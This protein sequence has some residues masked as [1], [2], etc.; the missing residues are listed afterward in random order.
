MWR[1]RRNMEL[2]FLRLR[3][4][5]YTCV[6]AAV[7]PLLETTNSPAPEHDRTFACARAMALALI[8]RNSFRRLSASHLALSPLKAAWMRV[9]ASGLPLDAA[10][11]V[12]LRLLASSP[13]ENSDGDARGVGGV[14][15]A[16]AVGG[17]AVL[18]V[19]GLLAALVALSSGCPHTLARRASS[20]ARFCLRSR[21]SALEDIPRPMALIGGKGK[22]V[23]RLSDSEFS[24]A[25]GL[26]VAPFRRYKVASL[27]SAY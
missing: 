5:V 17:E 9:A 13:T 12:L 4:A 15:A 7:Q 25:G 14:A 20:S 16:A 8:C 2:V 3:A 23:M 21:A 22:G 1:S 6:T 18:D 24:L 11:E 19:V 26:S 10:A 27:E